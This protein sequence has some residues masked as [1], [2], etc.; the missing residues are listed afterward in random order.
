MAWQLRFYLFGASLLGAL[1]GQTSASAGDTTRVTFDIPDKIECRDVTPEKCAAA[2][3]TLKVIEA[4]F[5]ISA[6]FID[7]GEANVVDFDYMI[8]SPGMRLKILDYLPNTT[9]ES[10][11]ADDR[12]E[13][14]D[15]TETAEANSEEARVGYSV[16]SLNASRSQSAKRTEQNHYQRV[17]P[18]SLV[19][20]SGT[21]NRGNGVFFKL[22]P[23]KGATLEGA[24]E[25]TFLAIVPKNWRGDWCTF[26]CVARYNKKSLVS[27]SIALAGIEN[28]H[29]G[30][31]L[32]GDHEAS[33][34]AS[35]LCQLQQANDG[36]LARQ[37]AK[38][39]A[40]AA[41]AM[42]ATT[43]NNPLAHVDDFFLH[44]VRFKSDS[45]SSDRRLETARREILDVEQQFAELAG[46]A[47]QATAAAQTATLQPTAK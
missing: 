3:P 26:V 37:F 5:R 13:V 2:H 30:L 17:A 24:K 25:F 23:S 1:A 11:Y 21:I 19:L 32:L 9:L 38:E 15:F 10:T 33:D 34:L 42:H 35:K 12:I 41:E 31:Y 18:K 6:S 43:P 16:L 14:A 7:G 20:A 8:T 28:A 22:R 36:V 29:V 27:T 47:V 44:L 4:K 46:S 45:K 40:K 39:A